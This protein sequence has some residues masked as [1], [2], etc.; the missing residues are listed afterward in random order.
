VR[1]RS[2]VVGSRPDRGLPGAALI[3]AAVVSLTTAGSVSAESAAINAN[4]QVQAIQVD[5]GLSASEVQAGDKLRA[6]AT[7]A[8]VGPGAVRVSVELRF[9]QR[10][11][12]LK[13][14]A[15]AAVPKLQ[16]GQSATVTWNLCAL[17][18]GQYVLLARATAGG[19]AT[20]SAA[21]VLTIAG[22]RRKGCT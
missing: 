22:Q 4:V 9:D 11:V 13:G 2:A 14:P 1:R 7:V 5:L 21:R 20:D 16:P 3:L 12:S 18:P 15:T 17:R 8:N 6:R 10:G 19:V